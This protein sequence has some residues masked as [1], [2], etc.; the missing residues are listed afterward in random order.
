[1]LS[2]GKPKNEID[3]KEQESSYSGNSGYTDERPTSLNL[4]DMNTDELAKVE[5]PDSPTSSQLK[6]D[7][8]LIKVS[9]LSQY[10]M[11]ASGKKYQS[12]IHKRTSKKFGKLHNNI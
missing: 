3:L 7:R 9:K 5:G 6:P 12:P 10:A 2:S 11:E 8:D 4:K 1:M